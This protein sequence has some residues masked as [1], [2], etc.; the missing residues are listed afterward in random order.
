[1]SLSETEIN[2]LLKPAEN[3]TQEVLPAQA[4]K[5][6]ELVRRNIAAANR[7]S[8]N[9]SPGGQSGDRDAVSGEQY[10]ILHRL[11]GW[12]VFF[13]PIHFRDLVN[14][15]DWL[16][17]ANEA[18]LVLNVYNKK[19]PNNMAGCFPDQT[20][21]VTICLE[22]TTEYGIAVDPRHQPYTA[23]YEHGPRL[24]RE[25]IVTV[26]GTLTLMADQAGFNAEG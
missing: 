4:Q 14:T 15:T 2:R 7:Y 1:M 22:P 8:S 25:N 6:G 10:K 9:R 16:L 19:L 20:T 5:L 11:G 3:T 24:D 23:R 12:L 26:L 21:A 18:E 13:V 17:H